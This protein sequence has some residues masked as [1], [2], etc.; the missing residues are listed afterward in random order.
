MSCHKTKPASGTNWFQRGVRGGGCRSQ[1]ALTV[2]QCPVTPLRLARAPAGASQEGMRYA[3]RNNL[4]RLAEGLPPELLQEP[5]KLRKASALRPPAASCMPQ[6]CARCSCC[7]PVAAP[8]GPS[9]KH[10]SVH[11]NELPPS[12][13]AACCP[14][15]P[16]PPCPCA[17]GGFAA[18]V[19]SSC[20]SSSWH[21]QMWR[22]M[23][24]RHAL[25]QA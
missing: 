8:A 2:P 18:A 3:L 13:L 1:Q 10:S 5:G 4:F 25:L 7:T 23:P 14:P 21:L 9:W 24:C 16:L 12:A 20:R 6:C 17:H 11:A 19:G 22:Q 15:S